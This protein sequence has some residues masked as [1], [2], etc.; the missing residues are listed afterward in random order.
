MLRK[1]FTGISYFLAGLMFLLCF[2]VTMPTGDAK[3][4]VTRIILV[5]HGQTDYNV[6]DL[7]QGSLDIP[8]NETGLKQAD[9]LAE[10]IKDLP[11][12]V[13]ISSPLERA[14]VT[15]EKCAKAKGMEISYTD[16]R[17]TEISYGDW[18]GQYKKD[19]AKKYKELAKMWKKEPWN[20]Q[21]PGGETLQQLQE[22]YRA[23][24]DDV[25]QRYPGKTIFIGAHSKGNMTLM[26]S[27]L[28]IGLEHYSQFKQDNTCI[29]VLEYK[30]G[31]WKLVL[32]NS[33]AHTGKLYKY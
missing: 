1:R 3:A 11:I 9:M 28:G 33:I 21:I 18:T 31:Q 2:V 13:F 16:P 22:R 5:R 29:N 32:L 4:Q 10:S 24:L 7:Y 30:K 8:L 17:L 23:A 14:Y 26:C 15:T 25:V 12:D 6:K 20:V 27:V 19:V